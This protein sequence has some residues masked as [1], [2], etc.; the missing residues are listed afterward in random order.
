MRGDVRSILF[1]PPDSRL[2]QI[3]REHGLT[4]HGGEDVSGAVRVSACECQ[5]ARTYLCL[6]CGARV[7]LSCSPP[8]CPHALALP[9]VRDRLGLRQVRA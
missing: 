4:D 6:L 7:A 2:R 1:D 9:G 8:P 5:A 3:V